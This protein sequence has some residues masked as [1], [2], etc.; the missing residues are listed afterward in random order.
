MMINPLRID[1]RWGN[2]L[3]KAVC[4]D[5]ENIYE[6]VLRCEVGFALYQDL[7]D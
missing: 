2:G 3:V 4:Y 6:V 5:D 7:V 1:G